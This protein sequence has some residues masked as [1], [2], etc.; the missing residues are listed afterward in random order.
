MALRATGERIVCTPTTCWWQRCRPCHRSCLAACFSSLVRSQACISRCSA[1]SRDSLEDGTLYRLS[2]HI[3][4]KFL[5]ALMRLPSLLLH[6][7]R[8]FPRLEGYHSESLF[9]FCELVW[10]LQRQRPA[11]PRASLHREMATRTLVTAAICFTR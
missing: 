8:V 9:L 2:R 1:A 6:R 3:Q 4:L 5:M 7:A 11:A 10:G